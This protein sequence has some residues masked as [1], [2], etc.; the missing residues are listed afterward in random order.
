MTGNSRTAPNRVIAIMEAGIVLFNS[1]VNDHLDM[2]SSIA[3][4]NF[5]AYIQ[6]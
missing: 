2:V 5:F 4:S 6:V 3:Y 1:M